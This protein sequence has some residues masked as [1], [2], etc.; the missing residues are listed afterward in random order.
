VIP[1]IKQSTRTCRECRKSFVTLSRNANTCTARECILARR[2][3]DHNRYDE[4][5]R[6]AKEQKCL[7][8]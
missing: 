5:N 2:R 6:R 7:T 8:K 3:K 4:R 1:S